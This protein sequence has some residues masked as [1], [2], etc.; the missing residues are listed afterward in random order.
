MNNVLRRL[1][2]IET[3]IVGSGIPT[4][5]RAQVITGKMKEG[6]FLP[7]DPNDSVAKREEALTRRYGSAKG[8]VFIKLIDS[9]G[10]MA[11]RGNQRGTDTK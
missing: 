8:A 9:F 6:R 3:A 5:E 2:K 7:A 11:S 10:P 4:A 1:E